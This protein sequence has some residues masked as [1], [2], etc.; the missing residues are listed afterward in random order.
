MNTTPQQI[1]DIEDALVSDDNPARD[2]G[3]LDYERCA[4]LHN[5]LVAYGWMARN[6]KDTPDVDALAS[7][8]WFFHDANEEVE[9]TRERL[10]APLNKFL[11]LVYDPRPPFFY[12]IDG[13]VM[14]LSDEYFIDDNEMEEDKE[15]FV[16]CYRTI[17]DLGGHNLGVVYDQQLNRAS[18]PMTT[19]NMESVEPI[20]EHEEMW[21]PLE[22]I[23]TQWIY[24]IRI[25]KVIPGLPEELPSGDS[26]TNRSQFYLWSWLPYCDAQ[27]D[28]TIAAIERYL[29]AVE[30]R[31]PPNSLLP[32][33][34]PLFTGAELDA[35]AVPQD[36]FIRSL[37]T[38]VKTPRFKFIAPGLEVPHDKEAFARRQRFTNIPYEEDS[39]PGVLLFAAPDRL[40]DLNLEIRRLFSTA[41]DNVSMN[42]NDPVPTGLYSEPV[43]RRD[44]DMEEAG[45]RLVLPFALR[46]G[47]FRD[48]DGA[49]MSDGRPVPSG[50]FTGLFQHGYFHPFGGERRSQRL[51]RLFERWIVLVERGIW[52]VGEDGVE[53]GIDK[54][55]DADRG[56]WNEYSIAPSW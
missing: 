49:R 19:D 25:G 6:G 3:T 53:G 7:E 13:L 43:R 33:S 10:N 37:L 24:M 34:A 48:E 29:A 46:P 2:D 42:D 56:A 30:S 32:I 22:T 9:A 40:V 15:R 50:S 23:L 41:H 26:P 4:R 18:F 17:P 35:A 44:Y 28:S 31:M 55:G 20:D 5:Y 11:D 45:F 8:K 21:F 47:F 52:T 51:E 12:W 27:I 1:L 39:I 14:E 16:L 54:F 38:R 36:C